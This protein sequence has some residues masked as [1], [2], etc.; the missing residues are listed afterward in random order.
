MKV[1][2]E[3]THQYEKKGKF[4]K[5]SKMNLPA[6]SCTGQ[7]RSPECPQNEV[8]AEGRAPG[9]VEEGG[10]RDPGSGQGGTPVLRTNCGWRIS[11]V[12]EWIFFK[13]LGKNL[14]EST[15]PTPTETHTYTHARADLLLFQN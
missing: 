15:P 8:P 12:T 3:D 7:R 14:R 1:G 9:R 13:S 4:K 2:A 11:V 6:P 10:R 5:S